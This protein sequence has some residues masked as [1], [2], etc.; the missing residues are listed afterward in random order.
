[1]R[2]ASNN[3]LNASCTAFEHCWSMVNISLSQ[4]KET[5]S[6]RSCLPKKI[7]RYSNPSKMHGNW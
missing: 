2:C 3:V 7:T 5:P 4:F 1:M 6:R